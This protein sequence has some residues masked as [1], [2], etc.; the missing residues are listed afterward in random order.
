MKPVKDSELV[1]KPGDAVSVQSE[2]IFDFVRDPSGGAGESAPVDQL[3][4]ALT[5]AGF[6]V[7]DDSNKKLIGRT[8]TGETKEIAYRMFGAGLGEVQRTSYTQRVFE[9]EFVVDGQVAWQRKRGMDAP[10]HLQ[11]QQNELVDQ[12]VQR[13]LMQDNGFFR[14][15]IPSRILPTPAAEARMSQLTI[16]GIK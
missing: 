6:V 16:D 8:S 15:T 12:A 1:L 13:V 5:R 14:S 11:L 7:V 3:K 4:E 2:M 10:H 9:L